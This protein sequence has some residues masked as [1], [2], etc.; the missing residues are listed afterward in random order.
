MPL[1]DRD[2]QKCLAVIRRVPFD[3]TNLEK[4]K[5]SIVPPVVRLIAR[6]AE[7][8]RGKRFCHHAKPRESITGSNHPIIG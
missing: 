3:V 6:P 5:P 1:H 2:F 7:D 8:H 4:L